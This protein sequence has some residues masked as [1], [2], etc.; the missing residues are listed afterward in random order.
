MNEWMN[1]LINDQK[2]TAER[3]DNVRRTTVLFL[4][5]KVIKKQVSCEMI[6]E[7]P[8]INLHNIQHNNLHIKYNTAV[9][10]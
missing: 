9:S 6:Q 10:I 4:C 3:S 1:E 8:V 7:Y 2:V 5:Y